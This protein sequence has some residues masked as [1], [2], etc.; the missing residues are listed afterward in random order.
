MT[1]EE[2]A[3]DVQTISRTLGDAFKEYVD[4]LKPGQRVAD[5]GYVKHYVTYVGYEQTI[6]ALSGSRVESYVETRITSTDP[7]AEAR[8]AA[9]KRWFQYLKKRGHTTENYGI[10][11]RVRRT[12]RSAATATNRTRVEEAPIEMTEEGIEQ[13]KRELEELEGQ[14]P[15]LVQ[16]IAVAR[17]DK[18][19]RENA[20]LDAAREALGYNEGRVKAIQEALKR[21]VIVSG[22]RDERSVLGS[23]VQVTRLNDEKSLTYKLV[24][25]NE[26]NA[27]E[28]RISVESP[29]GK[30][31]LGRG[32]GDE[33]VVEA[34]SG[35]IHLRID[36]VT[37]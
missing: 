4:S 7:N 13:L 1:S 19:F 33:V 23:T 12:G 9:L 16:A 11:V 29:V 21:A 24:S 30:Q 35:A 3:P 36:S 17:E 34:P 10:H 2:E 31:L 22:A 25:A 5:E 32:P 8:V 28:S 14:R 6:D 37:H 20:P 15:D 26:A 18:D 27:R